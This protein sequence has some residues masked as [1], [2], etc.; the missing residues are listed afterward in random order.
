MAISEFRFYLGTR[1]V[2]VVDTHRFPEK[3]MSLI[4]SLNK[5]NQGRSVCAQKLWLARGLIMWGKIGPIE[6]L[7]SY[8]LLYLGGSWH[9]CIDN[10]DQFSEMIQTITPTQWVWSLCP[11]C[12][13]FFSHATLV[14]EAI[15]YW[16]QSL[17]CPLLRVGV[18]VGIVMWKEKRFT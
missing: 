11:Y 10:G 18:V 8:S 17:V 12:L 1:R 4:S 16:R 7:L 9:T 14:F 13:G 6:A 5:I 15:L 3:Q 2:V